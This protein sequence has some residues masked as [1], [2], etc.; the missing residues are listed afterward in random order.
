MAVAAIDVL[1]SA[2]A[3]ALTALR[4]LLSTAVLLGTADWLWPVIVSLL[5]LSR[6]A[7]LAVAIIAEA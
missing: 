2:G 5:A 7:L 1:G 4:E 3:I 6:P